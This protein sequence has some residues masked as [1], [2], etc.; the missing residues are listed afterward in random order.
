[1]KTFG[2]RRIWTIRTDLRILNRRV[3][4]NFSVLNVQSIVLEV[5]VAI[6]GPVL[7]LLEVATGVYAI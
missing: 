6:K 5:D 1:M 2:T 7:D 4:H 3:I